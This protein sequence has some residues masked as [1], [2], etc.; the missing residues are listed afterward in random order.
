MDH[1]LEFLPVE[2][3]AKLSST[4]AV[5][6][7]KLDRIYVFGGESNGSCRDTIEYIDLH[8]PPL[9][10]SPP[11]NTSSS[12]SN[13]SPALSTMDCEHQTVDNYPYPSDKTS[14]FICL[15]QTNTDGGVFT[16]PQPLIFDPILRTCNVQEMM[17]GFP[18][19]EGKNGLQSYPNAWTKF[20]VCRGGTSHV[21]I[22]Q[23][24]EPLRFHGE[25]K[26]CDLHE[27]VAD[28]P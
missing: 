22:Y 8:S 9:P 3:Y 7:P 21:E 16:C 26:I 28:S 10:P 2:N 13:S 24:P 12:S 20:I 14:F 17:G 1:S 19:C 27:S 25:R 23:C 18:T 5:Y 11:L 6:I 4:S 15:N